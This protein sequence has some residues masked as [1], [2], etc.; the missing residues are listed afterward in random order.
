[1]ANAPSREI[2]QAFLEPTTELHRR[3]ELYEYDGVTP[4]A[5][6]L[7]PEI[8]VGGA[9][10]LDHARDERRS[11]DLELDNYAGLLN[12]EV[13]GFW[14]DKTIKVF[15]GIRV[16]Q[17]FREPRVII[18]EEYD[19]I[20][21]ARELKR[22]LAEAGVSVVHFNPMVET[23]A[24]IQDF[25]IIIS[26]AST[27][28][29]K[30]SLLTEAYGKGKS[31]LTFGAEATAAQ[32][33]AVISSAA[34]T[35]SS[36]T[37]DRSFEKADLADPVA[38]GWD[39][40]ILTGAHN[41]R[42]VLAIAPGAVT[43]ANTWDATN[44]FSP[45]IIMQT[46][47]NGNRWIHVVQGNFTTFDADEGAEY[48]SGFLYTATERLDYY[49]PQEIWETQIGE[50]VPDEIADADDAGERIKVVGRDYTARCMAS[51]L[52]KATAF[53][54]TESIESVIKALASNSGIRK[55]NLPVTGRTLGKDMTWERDT[56][57]WSIM[58]DVAVA[59]NYEIYFDAQ[60]YLRLEAQ[61]DPLLSPATLDLVT[62]VGGNL[63][64][65]NRKTS[66]M[67]IFN[68]VSVVGESSDSS[69]PL[70]YGEAKN[71]SEN[72]PT[73]IKYLGERTKNIT[74][75]L[76]TS[77]EQAMEIA[78]ALLAVSAL[79]EFS[80]DFSAVL[81]PWMEV[82]EILEMLDD[83]DTAWG[84]SKYLLSTLTLPLDLGPMSGAAK[85]IMKVG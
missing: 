45:G 85:R 83:S 36:I 19:A 47:L 67:N 30:L 4:Y 3:V 84:P 5:Q 17:E 10:G 15:F 40:W 33:P 38:V 64:S 72:S 29:R 31:I 66:G 74:N 73:A 56:D 11:L 55:M 82:G 57:R 20:G 26:V 65:R 34:S 81:F 46:N 63:V 35:I 24:E 14:Y 77:N 42:R 53:A 52:T 49:A 39:D 62:G 76:V 9:V 22:F 68:L 59:N 23:Y 50:F 41:Y 43:V 37:T 44:G 60:G 48:F 75:A 51:K 12:P 28:T 7:W 8:L 16:A 21:Q 70:C 69:I 79:E 1:M 27:Y 18:V 78:E 2:Q 6:S 13:G 58:K 61:R 32:M 80:L 54:A 71:T 25:D